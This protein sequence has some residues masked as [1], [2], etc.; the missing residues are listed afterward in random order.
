M[1]AHCAQKIAAN[2]LKCYNSAMVYYSHPTMNIGI[3]QNRKENQKPDNN[4]QYSKKIT[5]Q[6][7]NSLIQRTAEN[8]MLLKLATP[9]ELPRLNSPPNMFSIKLFLVR[10]SPL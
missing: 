7:L 10:F 6:K 9:R 2:E 5:T 8:C 4:S 3:T 1:Y